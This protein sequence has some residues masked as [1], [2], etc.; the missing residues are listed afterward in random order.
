MRPFKH[1][2]ITK[3]YAVKAAL[4]RRLGRKAGCSL[5]FSAKALLEMFEFES[6]GANGILFS[7][8]RTRNGYA[9]GKWL[10]DIDV[11]Q[12]CDDIRAGD[13]CKYEYLTTAIDRLHN[14]KLLAGVMTGASFG[15]EGIK[16]DT[17]YQLV[18]I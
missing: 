2:K 17:I 10:R 11:S 1:K 6:I 7:E 3:R 5:D 8:L 9:F 13:F 4:Y 12:M 15:W 14:A 18:E 16:Y